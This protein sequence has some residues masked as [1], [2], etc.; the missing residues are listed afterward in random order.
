MKNCLVL[1]LSILYL[2]LTV[3]DEYIALMFLIT[4]RLS[5][6]LKKKFCVNFE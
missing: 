3:A 1:Y 4:I 6:N 5:L 2:K